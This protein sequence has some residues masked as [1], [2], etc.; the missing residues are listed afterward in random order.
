MT[1]R[2]SRHAGPSQVLAC[3]GKANVKA[4]A[5]TQHVQVK[6]EQEFAGFPAAPKQP[7]SPTLEPS[8]SHVM[9]PAPAAEA[10]AVETKKK[11]PHKRRKV[12]DIPAELQVF[13]C[14]ASAS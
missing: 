2:S 4:K 3:T 10:G 14:I 9:P 7:G 1:K 13:C 11:R 12:E 6:E 8:V 5:E